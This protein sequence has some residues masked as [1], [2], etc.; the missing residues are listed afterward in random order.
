MAN[1]N[2]YNGE[3][4]TMM[5]GHR[6]LMPKIAKGPKW[7]RKK[8]YY[9]TKCLCDKCNEAVMPD[10]YNE[11]EI[12]YWD[13]KENY[14]NCITKPNSYNPEKKTIIVYVPKQL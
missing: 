6:Q 7:E 11:V 2:Y 12:S 14:S 1:T 8:W 9:R 3:W 5:C 4:I 13:Y 10:R